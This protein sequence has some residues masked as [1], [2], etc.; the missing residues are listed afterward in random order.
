MRNIENIRF[1]IKDLCMGTIQKRFL[2]CGYRKC[3]CHT[4]K[5]KK[6]GPFY[7]LV[8]TE[9]PS[10]KTKTKYLNPKI[11]DNIKRRIKNYALLQ[12][13]ISKYIKKE[14]NIK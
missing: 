11:V 3:P 9:K 7:Y 5:G 4:K 13:Y 2:T 10:N 12:E 14:L 8:Y 6:H 1:K